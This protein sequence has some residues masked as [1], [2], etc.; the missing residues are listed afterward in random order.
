MPAHYKYGGSTATRTLKC[1]AWAHLS[2]DVP[3]SPTSAA[4]AEG[5]SMHAMFEKGIIDTEYVTEADL[6]KVVEGV[7]VTQT[8]VDK[9]N[10]ALDVQFEMEF[11]KG[12]VRVNA[13]MKMELTEMIGGTA[14]I[15][16]YSQTDNVFCVGDL[17]TGDGLMVYADDNDQLKFYTY[18]AVKE[19]RGEFDFNEQTKF[20]LYIIQPSDRRD[21]PLDVW[22]TT[23]VDLISFGTEFEAKVK[24]AETGKAT[25]T[26]GSHCKYCPAEALCPNKTGLSASAMR[27]NPVMAEQLGEAMGMVEEVENWAKAVR[28]LAHEQAEQGVKITGWKLVSK[29]AT[30]VWNDAPVIEKKLKLMKKLVLKDYTE[31]K[32]MSPAKLEQLCKRKSVDFKQ[33]DEYISKHSSGTTLAL[34]SD[35]RPEQ[36]PVAGLVAMANTIK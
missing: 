17:K 12:C 1:P 32:L 21:E 4:A 10:I 25:P 14:D 34:E 33:F 28:K 9:V 6:G 7:T 5:T 31:Q 18:L 23:L 8:M 16:M 36:L 22:E 27:L 20:Y 2:K 15:V 35:K 3:P 13:E 19:M 26:A 11:D 29:R 30:R 24:M